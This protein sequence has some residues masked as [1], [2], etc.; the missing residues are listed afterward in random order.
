M[1]IAKLIPII[2]LILFPLNLASP[3]FYPENDSKNKNKQISPG[4]F[5]DKTVDKKYSPLSTGSHN[6][7]NLFIYL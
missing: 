3:R 4:F 2:P 7:N 1:L 5:V 6:N